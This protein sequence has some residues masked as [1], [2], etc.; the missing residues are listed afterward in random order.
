MADRITK[1]DAE[2][3]HASLVAMLGEDFGDSRRPWGYLT[4][5][6]WRVGIGGWGH[7]QGWSRGFTVTDNLGRMGRRHRGYREACHDGGR[8]E[9]RGWHERMALD[10]V[11]ALAAL[12]VSE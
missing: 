4:R 3:V 6:N 12:R 7:R 10:I 11:D 2:R 5:D 1:A 8:Y 9:G